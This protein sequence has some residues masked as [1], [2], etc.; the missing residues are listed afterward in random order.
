M[1]IGFG[2]GYYLVEFSYDQTTFI[3]YVKDIETE[4]EYI[5]HLPMQKAQQLLRSCAQDYDS[6]A[7]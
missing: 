2:K 6:F 4:D 1:I 5:K 3:I 7:E